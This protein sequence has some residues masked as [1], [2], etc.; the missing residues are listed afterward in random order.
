[1]MGRRTGFTLVELLIASAIS[2]I[3]ILSIYSAFQTGILSYGRLDSATTLFQTARSIFNRMELDLVNAFAYKQEDAK[4]SGNAASLDF[5]SAVPSFVEGESTP[6]VSRI[7][8]SLQQNSLQRNFFSGLDTLKEGLEPYAAEM[9]SEVKQIGFQYAF[10]SDNP[11]TPL[12]WQDFWPK[13]EDAA[14]KKSLPVAVKIKLSLIEKDRRQKEIGS[15][16]F[17]KV[18]LLP[19]GQVITNE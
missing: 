19:E 16:E 10:P 11:E 9:S 2:A 13:E 6:G 3:I 18:I 17:N 8:Y 5:F 14:Q 7:K 1:M 12:S 15:V 4:F